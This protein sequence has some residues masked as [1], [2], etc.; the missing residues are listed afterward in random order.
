MTHTGSDALR[1]EDA[2]RRAY[3]DLD[4]QRNRYGQ[5]LLQE[6]ILTLEATYPTFDPV[7]SLNSDQAEVAILHLPQHKYAQVHADSSTLRRVWPLLSSALRDQGFL[8]VIDI[9]A[10][11]TN[12]QT[13]PSD[14]VTWRYYTS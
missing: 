13:L 9:A 4:R 11:S 12:R 7:D 5:R 8:N 2:L 1:L 6:A 3:A 14:A 10:R